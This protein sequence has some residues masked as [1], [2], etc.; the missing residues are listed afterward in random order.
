VEISLEDIGQVEQILVSK[1]RHE[2][3]IFDKRCSA[4]SPRCAKRFLRNP[5]IK[6]SYH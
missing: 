3:S 1:A 2:A 6:L 5:S 4:A